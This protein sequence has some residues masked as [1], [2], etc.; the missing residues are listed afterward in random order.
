MPW[1]NKP[2]LP[3]LHPKLLTLADDISGVASAVGAVLEVVGDLLEVAKVFYLLVT[4]PYKALVAAL[5]TELEDLV[6]DMFSAGVYQLVIDPFQ[7]FSAGTKKDRWG[8]PLLT[9][10]DAINAALKSFDDLA[11]ENRPIFSPDSKVAALGIM[12][13]APSYG[14]LVSLLQSLWNVLGVEDIKW[15]LDK[16]ER[17]KYGRPK[18][19]RPPDWQ[20]LRLNEIKVMGDVQQYLLDTLAATKGY[21][22]TTDEIIQK[23]IDSLARK[24]QV[25]QD[26]ADMINMI[27][28]NIQNIADMNQAYIMDLPETYGGIERIKQELMHPELMYNKVNKY[29]FMYL[30]VGGGPSLKTCELLRQLMTGH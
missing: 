8:I 4:D 14:E 28:L 26:A 18:F 9:P 6:N 15:L 16:L 25:W 5:I 7:V 13:T 19:S 22:T 20:S 10:A 3:P 21:L 29:T 11:D 1:Q 17:E 27:V 30:C 2:L 12:V 24:V 23:M